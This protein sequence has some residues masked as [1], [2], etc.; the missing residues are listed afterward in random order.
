MKRIL[1]LGGASVLALTLA[2]AANAATTWYVNGRNGNDSNDCQSAQTA[3][4]TI[5]HAIA[6]VSS[7]DTVTVAASTYN[8]NL[9]IGSGITLAVIGAGATTTRIDGGLNNRVLAI[10]DAGANIT[11]SDV[12]I[13]KGAASGGGGILNWGTL[14]ISD[15]IISNNY[16]M[17]S[18]SAVGGAIFN[19]M[20]TLT[21]NNTTFSKNGGSTH[22]MWGGAID[23][24]GTATIYN[25]TFSAIS[26]M[27][28]H[29]AAAAQSGTT[30][31]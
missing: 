24:E 23:N 15:S 14:T 3:C 26:P 19:Y 30:A 29:S 8:E 1:K 16:A 11:L 4:K 5:G 10:E 27:V 13:R 12:T 17:S 25:S 18:Y 28:L 9:F 2:D 31:R 22:Q 7:G 21:V 20:G 6:L